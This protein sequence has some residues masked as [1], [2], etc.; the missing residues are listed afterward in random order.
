MEGVNSIADGL[1]G[2]VQGAG[3][4]GRGLPLGT[5]EEDLAAA[6]RK[7]GRRPETGLEVARSSAVSGRTNKGVCMSKSIPHAQKPSL[8]LH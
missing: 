6:Y 7:G 2:A 1:V 3:N 4:G 8:E 5:G